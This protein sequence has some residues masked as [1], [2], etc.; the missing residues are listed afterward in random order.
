MRIIEYDPFAEDAF[1]QLIELKLQ[2][3]SAIEARMIYDA[4]KEMLLREM[5]VLP[6]HKLMN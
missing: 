3:G 1:E 2:S 4:Y 6:S 5:S